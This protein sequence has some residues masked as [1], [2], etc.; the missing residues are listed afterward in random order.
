MA[1]P[2]AGGLRAE[3]ALGQA[4]RPDTSA[5]TLFELRQTSFGARRVHRSSLPWRAVV[6]A[7]KDWPT[8]DLRWDWA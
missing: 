2:S 8:W 6:W 1:K 7:W 5:N 3:P 4:F